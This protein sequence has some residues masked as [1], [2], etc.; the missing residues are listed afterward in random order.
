MVKRNTLK[1]MIDAVAREFS[2]AAKQIEAKTKE[3]LESKKALAIQ[4]VVDA[5]SVGI[6]IPDP[7]FIDE[8]DLSDEERKKVAK[9][10][11]LT[12]LLVAEAVS[13]LNSRAGE[14]EQ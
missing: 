1:R 13:N 11:V 5:G 12:S 7:G 2:E 3:L 10:T 14:E 6:L 4:V 9:N 8:L